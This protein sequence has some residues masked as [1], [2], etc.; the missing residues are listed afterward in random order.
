MIHD[1]FFSGRS[2]EALD[3]GEDKAKATKWELFREK[4][5]Q[6]LKFKQPQ[7]PQFVAQTI[8]LFF[9]STEAG[10]KQQRLKES[11]R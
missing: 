7:T 6:K 1:S 10:E 3:A 5:P 4:K 9:A 8:F 2:A 11:S